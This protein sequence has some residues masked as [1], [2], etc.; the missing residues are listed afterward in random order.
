MISLQKGKSFDL[1]LYMVGMTGLGSS[2]DEPFRGSRQSTGL[3]IHYRSVIGPRKACRVTAVPLPPAFSTADPHSPRCFIHRMRSVSSSFR[4]P[5]SYPKNMKEPLIA[6]LSY[7]EQATG[8][9]TR[10]TVRYTP[11][12]AETLHRRVSKTQAFYLLFDSRL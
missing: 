10:T 9:A 1:P 6:A 3:S 12:S 5:P 8:I 4:F 2:A 11:S 7:L